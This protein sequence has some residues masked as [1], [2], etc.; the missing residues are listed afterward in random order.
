MSLRLYGESYYTC[1]TLLQT[2]ERVLM[3]GMTVTE[4]LIQDV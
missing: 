4:P 2:Y 3:E 1:A